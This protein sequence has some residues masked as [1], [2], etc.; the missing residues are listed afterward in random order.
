MS[1]VSL[2]LLALVAFA[3]NSVLCRLAQHAGAIDPAS[4]STIRF[5]SGTA[6]LLVV[7][8]LNR[9]NPGAT[10]S[11]RTA[12]GAWASAAVL[13]LYAMPFSFAYVTLPAGTGALILFGSVQITMMSAALLTGERPHAV[14]WLG[15]VLAVCGLV[16]LVLPGLSAP[17]LGAAMLMALAG[18]AWGLYSL[19]GR[20]AANPLAQ[21]TQTFVRLVPLLLAA[22]VVTVR[23]SHVEAA[24]ALYAVASGAVA[25]GLGYVVWYQALTHLT[26][27]RAAVVQLAVPVLA[28]AGGVVFL[29]EALSLR[30][31]IAAALVLG[32]IALALTSRE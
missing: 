11:A 21:T 16:Y 5:V 7:S 1:T 3:A 12:N 23:Q 22:S 19:R 15:L 32:G 26:A 9:S 31:L 6:M 28:A 4:F 20:G 29:H 10:A 8:A 18:F 17:P 25:S 13:F 30:L 27:T 24:G 2:T 14:L